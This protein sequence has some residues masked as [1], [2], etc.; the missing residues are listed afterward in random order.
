VDS[1]HMKKAK[2]MNNVGESIMYGVN[3]IV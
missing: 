1:N 3:C 2:R